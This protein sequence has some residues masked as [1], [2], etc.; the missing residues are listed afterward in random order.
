MIPY[1]SIDLKKKNFFFLFDIWITL[2]IFIQ[3]LTLNF[4]F[5][6][7]LTRITLTIFIQVLT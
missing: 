1:T 7:Y 3:V 4:F 5:F 6:F 2:T